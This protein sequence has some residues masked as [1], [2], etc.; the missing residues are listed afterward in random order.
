MGPC[1]IS[2]RAE[3]DPMKRAQGDPVKPASLFNPCQI[4]PIL[5][6]SVVGVRELIRLTVPDEIDFLNSATS[7]QL[8]SLHVHRGKICPRT[9]TRRLGIYYR[10]RPFVPFHWRPW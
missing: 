9:F 4:Y 10:I 5:K 8:G 7:P 2:I 6:A 3:G 1:Q